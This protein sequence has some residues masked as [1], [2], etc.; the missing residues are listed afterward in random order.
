MAWLKGNLGQRFSSRS[1]FVFR[2]LSTFLSPVLSVQSSLFTSSRLFLSSARVFYVPFSFPIFYALLASRSLLP[3]YPS[4]FILSFRSIFFF[5]LVTVLFSFHVRTA[6]VPILLRTGC[7]L[8]NF[9]FHPFSFD[10]FSI[11]R[12]LLFV[13]NTLCIYCFKF[14]LFSR[15]SII[16]FTLPL[17]KSALSSSSI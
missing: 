4:R 12:I 1:S 13:Y 15:W 7:L 17:S 11:F 14:S 5:P 3:L 8:C 2:L 10:F 9:Y 16:H 6:F